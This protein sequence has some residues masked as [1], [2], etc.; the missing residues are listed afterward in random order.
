MFNLGLGQLLL[1][2]PTDGSRG[3]IRVTYE[4]VPTWL[5]FNWNTNDENNDGNIFDDNPSGVATF[6]LYRGNDR[7]I[8]WREVTN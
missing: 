3:Q 2:Q 8:S 6:G 4:D 7:I 5:K 1:S